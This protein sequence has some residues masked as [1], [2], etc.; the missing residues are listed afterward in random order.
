MGVHGRLIVRLWYNGQGML[1]LN[2]HGNDPRF[3]TCSN[4]NVANA[5][6]PRKRP[7]CFHTNC[8][9]GPDPTEERLQVTINDTKI[10]GWD[11]R[12]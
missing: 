1:S 11:K 10:L 9:V 5:V 3:V 12:W 8:F 2:S 6:S 7:S 4:A